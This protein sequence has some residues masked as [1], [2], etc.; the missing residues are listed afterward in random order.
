MKKY[1]IALI[2]FLSSCASATYEVKVNAVSAPSDETLKYNNCILV[3]VKECDEKSLVYKRYRS[4]ITQIVQENNV[5]IVENKKNANCELFF[6]YGVSEPQVI[7]YTSMVP[8]YGVTNISSS[9]T[10]GNMYSFGNYGSYTSQTEYYPQYGITGYTPVTRTMI[11]YSKHLFLDARKMAKGNEIGDQLWRV[12]TTSRGQSN[13][14]DEI[15]PYMLY[16]T[17][18]NIKYNSNNTENY[19]LSAND[20]KIQYY[21]QIFNP[22][23]YEPN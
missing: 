18:N 4:F 11:V 2:L 13:D 17:A 22:E 21:K 20:K 5:N 15:M 12:L 9:T 19:I 23:L 16:V 10:T 14:L 6:D 7:N 1:L 3:P 8:N